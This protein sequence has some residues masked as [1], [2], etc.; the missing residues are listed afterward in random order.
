MLIASGSLAPHCT[1]HNEA[2]LYQFYNVWGGGNSHYHKGLHPLSSRTAV[3]QSYLRVSFF[4]SREAIYRKSDTDIS[5][6]ATE[7]WMDSKSSFGGLIVQERS[8]QP[9]VPIISCLPNQKQACDNLILKFCILTQI[10]SHRQ[11]KSEFWKLKSDSS[12]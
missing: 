11:R 4:L 7:L 10:L 9:V 5:K 3:G 1:Y 12:K 8:F 2:F 6:K